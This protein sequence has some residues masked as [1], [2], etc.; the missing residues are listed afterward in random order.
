ERIAALL[1][2]ERMAKVAAARIL[3]GRAHGHALTI[4]LTYSTDF[5]GSGGIPPEPSWRSLPA[6]RARR[7][8]AIGA[9]APRA[10]GAGSSWR[11]SRQCACT[12]N[13]WCLTQPNKLEPNHI[14]VKGASVVIRN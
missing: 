6:E 9:A 7:L 13:R 4:C 10:Q 8:R 14:R 3:S 2:R 1:G 12:T 5:E 11:R